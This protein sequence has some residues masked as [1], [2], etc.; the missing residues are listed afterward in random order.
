MKVADEKS[1]K[2]ARFRADPNRVRVGIRREGDKWRATVGVR[3]LDS[4]GDEV[5][6]TAVDRPEKVITAAL[7]L[8]RNHGI[9]GID[10]DMQWTYPHPW[11]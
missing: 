1:E 7:R 4:V 9:K 10:L 3:G 11:P 6:V 8:A 2:L 5:S